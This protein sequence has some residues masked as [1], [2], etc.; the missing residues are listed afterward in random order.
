MGNNFSLTFDQPTTFTR[1]G[2]DL[3]GWHRCSK[4]DVMFLGQSN[5]ETCIGGGNHVGD[6]ANFTLSQFVPEGPNAQGSW[7]LCQACSA[8]FFDGF[9][10]K[11]LCP[12][13]HHLSPGGLANTFGGHSATMQFDFVLPH[14]LPT[15][16]PSKCVLSF[17]QMKLVNQKSDHDHSDNDWLSMVW[18]INEKV[19]SKTVPLVNTTGTPV[20][21]TGD[22]L[23][24]YQDYV[25]CQSI[26]TV[27]VVFTVINL[28][29]YD[30]GKQA[31]AAAKFTQGVLDAVVPIY[32]KV[33]A[34]VLTMVS[35]GALPVAADFI[36]ALAGES[37]PILDQFS[38]KIG[39][40]IDGAFDNVITPALKDVVE[41]FAQI[42]TG[43]PN[44]NGEVLHDYVI[45]LPNQPVQDIH[46]SKT[47]PGPQTNSSCGTPP[48]TTVDI[49]MHREGIG[50][51]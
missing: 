37:S 10:D 5:K 30:F 48:N 35:D 9:P 47:Y 51:H 38:S 45:F 19:Y 29:S 7:R 20:L 49:V 2:I 28:G 22:V 44:C 18:M 16:V 41:F 12:A 43:K 6:N 14:D 26:D 17:S 21:H 23:Q 15:S 33:A 13:A 8:L 11:G 31:E 42:L 34:S 40:A 36:A 1:V 3:S 4:C 32:M 24:P 46:I 50:A 39:D 27:I 25:L